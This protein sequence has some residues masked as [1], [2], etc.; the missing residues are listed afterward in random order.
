MR[1]F[2]ERVR[3]SVHFSLGTIAI[4]LLCAAPVDAQRG[5]EGR[6]GGGQDRAQLEQRMRA[7][8]ARVMKERLGL[9]DEQ[10]VRL[11]EIDQ[12][13]GV[14]RRELARSEQAARRRV[15]ALLIEESGDEVEAQE[16]LER[17]V[18]L[19]IQEADIFRE[20]QLALL[21]VLTPTQI[22]EMQS[23]REQ[24]G[25]RIRALRSRGDDQRRPRRG[26]VRGDV[27]GRG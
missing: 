2:G 25:E 27:D 22:L 7:Q 1:G 5:P 11:G 6:R 20:E 4:V 9:T 12:E 19:R 24:L 23:L 17:M 26:G 21:E 8:I 18:Q 16:L 13:F 3:R 14:R 10:A 15:E